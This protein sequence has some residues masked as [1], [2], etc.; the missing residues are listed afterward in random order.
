MLTVRE[1]LTIIVGSRNLALTDPL[2]GLANRRRLMEDLHRA[3]HLASPSRPWRLVMYDLNGFKRYNDTFGH[4][5]GDALLARLGNRLGAS[6]SAHG[7]AY[8]LGGDEFCVLVD[9]QSVGDSETFERELEQASVRALSERGQEYAI[10][11]AHGGVSI[12]LEAREPSAAL[13]LAD[14]RLYQR[15]DRPILDPF[16]ATL[17]AQAPAHQRDPII[18]QAPA[19]RAAVVQ[20]IVAHD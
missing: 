12:P 16:L 6:V 1:N 11:A 19:P 3:C 20:A 4:P 17:D 5:A 8:R 10:G 13:A 9:L 14:Q 18:A 15:K 2:T 7:M